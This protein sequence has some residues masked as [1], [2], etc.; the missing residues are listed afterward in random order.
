MKL[1][2]VSIV[3]VFLRVIHCILYTGLLFITWFPVYY[4]VCII[5]LL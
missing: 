3:F 5:V 4:I 2:F 1:V